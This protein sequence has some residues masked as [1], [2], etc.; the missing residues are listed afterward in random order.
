MSL[1]AA[2]DDVDLPRPGTF[3]F[4]LALL[5]AAGRSVAGVRIE[6]LDADTGVFY[7]VVELDDGATLD[8]RPSDA[9]NVAVRAGVPI[10]VA[11]M[12]LDGAEPVP[13]GGRGALELA[14]A[15]R[16]RLAQAG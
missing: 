1:A 4:A 7:A 5:G 14:V 8:A 12:L 6:R 15:L 3:A 9:L 11:E 13:E 10:R 2:L 16:E